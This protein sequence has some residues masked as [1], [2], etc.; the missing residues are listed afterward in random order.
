MRKNPYKPDMERIEAG[1]GLAKRRAMISAQPFR[2]FA[3]ALLC[4]CGARVNFDP[5]GGEGGG[6][7]AQPQDGGASSVVP[8][9]SACND[10]CE[11]NTV[12]CNDTEACIARCEEV[13]GYLGMCVPLFE[14]LLACDADAPPPDPTHCQ[15]VKPSCQPELEALLACVYPTGPCGQGEC[16][17]GSGSGDPAMEC[18]VTCGDVTYSTACNRASKFDP[19]PS[20]CVCQIDGVDVGTCQ[21]FS[22]NGLGQL[23]CCSAHF[24]ESQ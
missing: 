10:F 13:A 21:A 14:A 16:V 4:A 6:G 1:A 24:A 3:F 12:A 11:R 15:Y 2:V 18:T 19:Y 17:A 20:D 22:G 7:G 8:G 9:E 5:S 23:G